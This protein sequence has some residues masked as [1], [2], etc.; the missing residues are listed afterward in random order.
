MEVVRKKYKKIVRQSIVGVARID[1]RAVYKGEK[2]VEKAY[3]FCLPTSAIG[4]DH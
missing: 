4:V 3:S 1:A 2:N